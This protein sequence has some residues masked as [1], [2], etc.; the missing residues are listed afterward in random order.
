MAHGSADAAVPVLRARRDA[1]PEPLL[2]MPDVEAAAQHADGG[3]VE[4][5]ASLGRIAAQR[6]NLIAADHQRGVVGPRRVK[7][8]IKAD[9]VGGGEFNLIAVRTHGRG[10]DT[11]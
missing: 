1:S 5:V 3:D 2:S 6:A 8:E 10:P 11:E 7:Q 4:Q 9:S